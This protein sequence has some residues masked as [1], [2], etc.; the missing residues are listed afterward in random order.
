[1]R[2]IL[3]NEGPSRFLLFV[4]LVDLLD[5]VP[6]IRDLFERPLTSNHLSDVNSVCLF[7]SLV[8][9]MSGY[10]ALFVENILTVA[11]E[12]KLS[13][14]FVVLRLVSALCRGPGLEFE[15]RSVLHLLLDDFYGA[16]Y[17]ALR[18]SQALFI[19]LC[20]PC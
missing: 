11:G 8:E 10:T 12:A 5:V 16:L 13:F 6:R 1:M 3:A 20:G 17:S 14:E 18:L 15:L 2:K 7:L 19:G 4:F 9:E